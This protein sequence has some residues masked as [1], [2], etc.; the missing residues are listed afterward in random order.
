MSNSPL[1]RPQGSQPC[2][3]VCVCVRARVCTQSCLTQSCLTLCN[4]M[5]CSSPGSSVH[6]IFQARIMEWVAIFYFRGSSQLRIETMSPV[7]PALAGEF[8]TNCATW[9]APQSSLL[10][11]NSRNPT[12]LL[13]LPIL[14]CPFIQFSLNNPKIFLLF[15]SLT[16]MCNSN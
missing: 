3:C 9:D 2:V 15:S 12:P 13:S 14:H 16:F 4:P 5:D 7:S 8:F 1:A 6:G 10:L 11:I